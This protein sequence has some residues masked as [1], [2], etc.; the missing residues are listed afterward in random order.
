MQKKWLE[1]LMERTTKLVQNIPE[2][3]LYKLSSFKDHIR[4]KATEIIIKPLDGKNQDDVN[5]IQA[6]P[7]CLAQMWDFEA[8][9]SF[10][11]TLVSQGRYINFETIQTVYDS[12]LDELESQ[13]LQEDFKFMKQINRH[14][15]LLISSTEN[16]KDYNENIKFLIFVWKEF[17]R[18][19]EYEK[20]IRV[21]EKIIKMKHEDGYLYLGLLYKKLNDFNWAITFF[22]AGWNFY[23]S[24]IY[25]ENIII[26]LCENW[27]IEQAKRVYLDLTDLNVFTNPFILYSLQIENDQDLWKLVEMMWKKIN[28]IHSILV[29]LIRYANDYIS[30][31]LWVVENQLKEYIKIVQNNLSQREIT[32]VT[33]LIQ[34]KLYL[35]YV[36]INILKNN[37]YLSSHLLDINTLWFS[38]DEYKK[39]ILHGFLEKNFEIDVSEELKKLWEEDI[40]WDAEEI[41]SDENIE[42]TP[43]INSVYFSLNVYLSHILKIHFHWVNYSEISGQL[44]PLISKCLNELQMLEEWE[45]QCITLESMVFWEREFMESLPNDIAQL[46]HELVKNIDEIYGKFFRVFLSQIAHSELES[47]EKYSTLLS[48]NSNVACFFFI[49]QIIS[50]KF[51]PKDIDDSEDIY[52]YMTQ[53]TEKYW[54]WE[55]DT[56]N[57]ILFWELLIRE[58]WPDFAINFLCNGYNVIDDILWLYT[59]LKAMQYL[60][61]EEIKNV[62]I[63][64]DGFCLE[65][66]H[67]SSFFQYVEDFI[68]DGLHQKDITDFEK[69]YILL[70]LGIS[71][72]IQKQIPDYKQKAINYFIEATNFWSIE[73]LLEAWHILE[74]NGEYEEALTYY[75]QALLIHSNIN[76]L[77]FILGLTISTW[78]FDIAEKYIDYWIKSG[79]QMGS[80][81]WALLVWKTKK[82]ESLEQ[83]LI[84]RNK[85]ID[86]I[87]YPEGTIQLYQDIVNWWI[88]IEPKN[89]LWYKEKI[90]SLYVGYINDND[91]DHTKI[92]HMLETIFQTPNEYLTEVIN[93]TFGIILW[94]S[95]ELSSETNDEISMEYIDY[96]AYLYYDEFN[97]YFESFK[98]SNN[99]TSMQYTFDLKNE[100]SWLT[101]NILSKFSNNQKYVNKWKRNLEFTKYA[102]VE[103][104]DEKICSTPTL[105]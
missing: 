104:A 95:F 35:S 97:T 39:S 10:I 55:I 99:I 85:S 42:S 12:T 4:K 90:L 33:H 14:I 89:I 60:T 77:S 74:L 93:M 5:V 21:Y 65:R 76:V 18:K 81:I 51:I 69:K 8:A 94:N 13:E 16:I 25:L 22:E 27:K 17:E 98:K 57:S 92:I 40:L 1:E 82:I 67:I 28:E 30:N 58:I 71:H 26:T 63:E 102:G 103:I 100:I 54:L 83:Y 73:A 66:F 20:A 56:A 36:D 91:S 105:Q 101:L 84:L 49:E 3:I 37:R 79:Y 24:Q 80:Y 6:I 46:Y 19:W 7:I 31:Q 11:S 61:A 9:L 70:T 34:R 2:D 64:L 96:F 75:E 41:P 48:K 29:P 44:L 78:K 72:L 88:N 62:V 32:Q 68:Q 15:S 52:K 23:A 87:D 86:I 53:I 38:W 59:I 45:Q 50:K 47:Y 43:F